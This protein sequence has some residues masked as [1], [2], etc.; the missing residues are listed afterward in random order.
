HCVYRIEDTRMLYVP[1][2]KHCNSNEPLY[3]STFCNVDLGSNFYFSYSY[4]LSS[5]LQVHFSGISTP[6]CLLLTFSFI[7]LY[8]LQCNMT[9]FQP[10]PSDYFKYY[11][12]GSSKST[13]DLSAD[14]LASCKA[15]VH[16]D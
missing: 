7:Y 15:K 14:F 3:R 10:C 2:Q 8:C 1:N 16:D 5:T 11:G 4:D 6:N 13:W 12:H 9:S